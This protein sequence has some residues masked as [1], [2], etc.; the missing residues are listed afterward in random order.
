MEFKQLQSFVAVV[1]YGSFTKAAEK[2]YV[3]Q[4]TISSHISAL[5]AELR[6]TLIVRTTK[7]IEITA[8]GQEIY[9]YAV[10]ILELRERM[11]GACSEEGRHIIYLGA[12]TIPSAYILPEILPEFGQI[13]PDTYFVIHQSDSQGVIDGLLDGMFDIG[14]IG[15]REDE[16]L[17]CEPFCQDRMVLVTPVTDRFLAM[18]NY[19]DTPLDELLKE[20]I[21]LREKGSG[22]GRSAAHF[23]ES[24]GVKEEQLYVTA[25]IN[26]QETTKY[27]VAGGL[28]ISIISERAAR[29]FVEE[30]RLLQF[31]LP[32]ENC[33]SLYLTYRKDEI[34]KPHIRNFADF[35][36]QKY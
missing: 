25:R 4:P 5:E 31:E 1:K 36:L 27:L 9:E 32:V 10:R 30:K 21:I 14:L 26:D 28:G 23:L 29:S 11:I 12:S 2:L 34:L 24:I 3:S 8:K 7:S 18:Q 20:P 16:K 22:S 17:V 19:P 35:V 6:K 15:M 13:Y 33:R